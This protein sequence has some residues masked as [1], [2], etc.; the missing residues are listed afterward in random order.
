MY[1]IADKYLKNLMS[2]IKAL[3]ME[4]VL[5]FVALLEK[6]K[7]HNGT[8]YVFGNGG[9]AS[10]ASHF[11]CDVGKGLSYGKKK[12]YRIFC[13]N[14]NVPTMLAY[15]NDVS[16]DDVFVEQLKNHITPKD[17]VIG[18]SGSGN[19]ENIVRALDYS[20]K[21][22]TTTVAITGYPD[23]KAEHICFHTVKANIYNMQI[24]EDMHMILVHL[25]YT[26]L[27]GVDS[28]P[29]VEKRNSRSHVEPIVA[30]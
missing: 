21:V 1:D 6:T 26:I 27:S 22:G 10:T 16:F 2:S 7:E 17:L 25:I 24:A 11:A 8:I 9:S 29:E 23:S 20:Q 12:R 19:S 3:D 5:Q 15:A 13:L 30:Q 28:L 18:I 4:S 14:D